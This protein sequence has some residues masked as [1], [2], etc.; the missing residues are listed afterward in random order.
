MNLGGR[1]SQKH[2]A[3]LFSL[4]RKNISDETPCEENAPGTS[5]EVKEIKI[6]SLE[7][8]SEVLEPLGLRRHLPLK[9]HFVDEGWTNRRA[10]RGGRRTD[11]RLQG[12]TGAQGHRVL[13]PPPPH[14]L[15]SG[16]YLF[17][18]SFHQPQTH[19]CSLTKPHT[20]L[21]VDDERRA[22]EPP[23]VIKRAALVVRSDVHS[24]T[25]YRHG[26]A[27]WP[28]VWSARI[29][30]H[31]NADVCL[32]RPGSIVFVFRTFYYIWLDRVLRKNKKTSR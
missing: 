14:F 11:G 18:H 15:R 31:I 29:F 9:L 27:V 17:L 32:K 26:P 6:F 21:D 16:G 23:W 3:D 4:H 20:Q 10:N 1:R 5:N 2:E 25:F 24:V 13:T 28:D 30:L 8:R 12:G 7:F 22:A 19:L